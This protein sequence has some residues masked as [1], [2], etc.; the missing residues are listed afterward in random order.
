MKSTINLLLKTGGRQELE[1]DVY[2]A[3]A[4]HKTIEG[5]L[6]AITHVPTGGQIIT[7]K[8]KT[9]AVGVTK[10]LAG[11]ADWSMVELDCKLSADDDTGGLKAWQKKAILNVL[12]ESHNL[13]TPRKDKKCK[14]EASK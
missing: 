13:A 14:S 6:W 3:L 7:L 4:V 5:V 1:A 12:K 9:D 10:V 11:L 2:G 8:Y